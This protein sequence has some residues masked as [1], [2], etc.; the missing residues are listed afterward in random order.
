M[1]KKKVPNKAEQYHP[2][3]YGRTSDPDSEYKSKEDGLSIGIALCVIEL[4]W[5]FL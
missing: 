2:D 1:F 4:F 5:F 3:P